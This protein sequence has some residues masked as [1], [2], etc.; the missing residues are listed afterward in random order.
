RAAAKL[1]A[2]KI[3]A[4][5]VLAAAGVA[6][7][8]WA[9]F[10]DANRAKE[11]LRSKPS[12]WWIKADGLAGGKGSVLAPSIGEGCALLDDWMTRGMLGE[13][14]RSVVI[15]EP[16]EGR[17]VS[18]MALVAGGIVCFLPPSRDYKRLLDGGR[19]PNT[20]G[21]GAF[22][23]VA[24]MDGAL[25]E[26]VE[27]TIFR[28]V[29]AE[30][31][32]RGIEYRGF[33]YAGLMLTARGPRVLEFNVRLGDPEAQVALP[34]LNCDLAGVLEEALAGRLRAV[35]CPARPGAAVCV[36]GT[37]NGY[38][39]APCV[40]DAVT[41]VEDAWRLIGSNGAV[42]QAG[43][44]MKDGVLV[45]DGGRVLG[46]TAIGNSLRPAREMA[47]EALGRISWRGM[48]FRRDIAPDGE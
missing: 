28:P 40:G 5:E 1:E 24:E 16:L 39:G 8:Q 31:L 27:R 20:G 25:L 36:V 22:A 41:G 7:H 2:S 12:L 34:L 33:L 30:L 13:A 47:Y 4:R 14:G 9:S 38:P 42:F 35:T 10:S 23:P 44:A 18:L 3:F 6:E 37:A 21:M 32:E 11:F 17:E 45:T 26:Q 15:E 29:L 46:V 43:T 19:G 48:H